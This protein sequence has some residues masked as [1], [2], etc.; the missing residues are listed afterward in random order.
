MGFFAIDPQSGHVKIAKQLQSKYPEF[1]LSIKVEDGGQPSQ[2]DSTTL[3]ILLSASI[4]SYVKFQNDVYTVQ[5]PE[6]QRS[7]TVI[8]N[9]AV[10]AGASVTYS[11]QDSTGKDFWF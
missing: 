10:E 8:G 11:L 7:G 2:S 5:L 6:N 9:V 4:Q 1:V 3:R